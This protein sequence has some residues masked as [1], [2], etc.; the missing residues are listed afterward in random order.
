MS[1]KI[2]YQLWVQYPDDSWVMLGFF[3]DPRAAMDEYYLLVNK[4]EIEGLKPFVDMKVLEVR[5][6]WV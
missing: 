1:T 2:I 6:V 4:R 3:F 5:E